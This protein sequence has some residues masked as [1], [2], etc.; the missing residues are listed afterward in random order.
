MEN[1]SCGFGRLVNL[2]LENVVIVKEKFGSFISNCPLLEQLRLDDCSSFD[3]LKINA[4]NLKVFSF[5]GFFK[6]I[7]FKSTPHLAAI[8]IVL[9]P[10]DANVKQHEKDKDSELVKFFHSLP[11]IENLYLDSNILKLLDRIKDPVV[12]YLQAQDFTN[13]SLNQLRKLKMQHF[14]GFEPEMHFVK[15]LLAHSTI[16][17]K[18]TILANQ[19]TSDGKGFTYKRVDTISQSISESRSHISKSR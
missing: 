6:L 18:M 2:E 14:S 11:A 4:P 16:L 5:L 15:I 12:E 8:S 1:S 10:L 9:F 13:L 19:G 3:S 17:K 7:S